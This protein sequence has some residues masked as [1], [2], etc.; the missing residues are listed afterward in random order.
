MNRVFHAALHRRPLSHRACFARASAGLL[1]LAL[2]SGARS[3]LAGGEGMQIVWCGGEHFIVEPHGGGKVSFSAETR[4]A[5]R[6]GHST[7][8]LSGPGGVPIEIEETWLAGARAV[9]WEPQKRPVMGPR[10]VYVP[11]LATAPEPAAFAAQL[12]PRGHVTVLILDVS[13]TKQALLWTRI[14]EPENSLVPIAPKTPGGQRFIGRYQASV[15]RHSAQSIHIGYTTPYERWF[16][17]LLGPVTEPC[18]AIVTDGAADGAG[19]DGGL[20]RAAPRALSSTDSDEPSLS[21]KSKTR[22]VG[23]IA[24][25][26]AARGAAGSANRGST[27]RPEAPSCRCTT[28]AG[29]R[30]GWGP[31]WLLIVLQSFRRRRSGA[32][33][34]KRTPAKQRTEHPPHPKLVSERLG[35]APRLDFAR[36]A[37]DARALTRR[38]QATTDSTRTIPTQT[39]PKQTNPTQ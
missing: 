10:V 36:S 20:N 8:Q 2:C 23:G 5:Q 32:R 12:E 4:P 7:R 21:H 37:D 14:I 19:A 3:A 9:T 22:V 26:A 11:S 35:H 38:S 30:R 34:L 16:L 28:V 6:S 15:R 33:A 39:I 24:S 1:L 25:G 18:V 17:E 13:D 31:V 27:T 29:P